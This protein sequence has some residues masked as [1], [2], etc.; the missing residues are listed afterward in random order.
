[1]TNAGRSFARFARRSITR[2]RGPWCLVVALAWIAAPAVAEI[3]VVDDSG[4][5]VTL[6]A[7]A[8]RIVTLAPHATE[9]AYAAGAG[10]A[11]VG[12][13]KGS[14]FPPAARL[15]PVIGDATALDL[16]RIVMLA[17][18]LIVTWPW[19][20]PAQV[21]WLRA[22]GIAVFEADPRSAGGIADDV[23]RIGALSGTSPHAR[24]SASA[25]RAKLAALKRAQVDEPALR[26]FYQ[27]SDVPLF[28]LGGQHLVNEAISQCGG[29]NVFA[30]LALPAP[31]VSVEAVLAADPQVIV[32]GTDGAER[33]AWLE[34]WRQWTGID[35]VRR[36][37]LYAVDANLLHRPGPRFIDGIA[38][39]CD[40]LSMAR[41]SAR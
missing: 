19:T 9:L 32:A 35:A 33:P 26:V 15:L 6:A 3:R 1:M 21:G 30:A 23:E 16:E 41:R 24:A 13:V 37:A 11:I 17:P 34:R 4:A 40:V 10:S 38:Q 28:T 5:S 39:L 25:L 12:V 8:R 7:P 36:N 22:R 20:T 27:V 14:D 31:Q 2:V 18:D 29:R